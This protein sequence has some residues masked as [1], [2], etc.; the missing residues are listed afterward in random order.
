MPLVLA[1]AY[2]F[3]LSTALLYLLEYRCRSCFLGAWK[4]QVQQLLAA[5]VADL[6]LGKKPQAQQGPEQEQQQQQ[7]RVKEPQAQQSLEQEQEQQQQQK[8]QQQRVKKPQAQQGPEHQQ[9]QRS[10]EHGNH[11]RQEQ[12][13][14]SLRTWEQQQ[15]ERRQEPEPEQHNVASQQRRRQQQ[16]AFS[17]GST[18]SLARAPAPQQQQDKQKQGSSRS[19]GAWE[20]LPE[21]ETVLAQPDKPQNP[22]LAQQEQ[23]EQQQRP[24][25]RDSDGEVSP[26]GKQ[27][28]HQILQHVQSEGGTCACGD[29]SSSSCSAG[30]KQGRSF[31]RKQQ[32][33][34]SKD[35]E[36]WE[37]QSQQQQK[38]QPLQEQQQGAKINTH[39]QHPYPAAEAQPVKGSPSSSMQ[40]GDGVGAITRSSGSHA[41]DW[42]NL[43]VPLQCRTVS[44]VVATL[45]LLPLLLEMQRL[46]VAVAIG[47]R[48]GWEVVPYIVTSLV[49]KVGLRA[50]LFAAVEMAVLLVLSI[51]K[52]WRA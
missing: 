44:C 30:V 51:R 28:L 40:S 52:A 38:Q 39:Q 34:A 10:P 32:H 43:W 15:Q 29:G 21:D 23:Q 22:N 31:L 5:G 13:Q 3:V 8:Q 36:Q 25:L 6:G 9:K 47:L 7:Q 17:S 20:I 41:I 49:V 48:F 4:E 18:Q 27:L 14:L 12:E 1:G 45:S 33:G 50:A 46:L 37:Q 26:V 16:L 2:G 42:S 11:H 35:Q 19:A 24:H